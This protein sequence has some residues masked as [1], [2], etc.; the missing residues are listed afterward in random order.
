MQALILAV[1]T[2]RINFVLHLTE[3]VGSLTPFIFVTV[4][5]DTS[6]EHQ[7]SIL[8]DPGERLFVFFFK[9][10]LHIQNNHIYL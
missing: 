10:F 5:S 2:A 8:T 4:S 9:I 3:R 1:I 6:V 7:N